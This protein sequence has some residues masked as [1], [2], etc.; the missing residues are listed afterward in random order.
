MAP[1]ELATP[2]RTC[3]FADWRKTSNGRRHPEGSGKCLYQFP[4]IP[5]PLWVHLPSFGQ[6]IDRTVRGFITGTRSIWWSP[7]TQEH[8]PAWE[9]GT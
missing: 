2:C 1:L 7:V 5:L 8:C 3:A 9:R 6:A 4:E